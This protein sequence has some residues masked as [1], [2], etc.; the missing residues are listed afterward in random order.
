MLNPILNA[1][2]RPGSATRRTIDSEHDVDRC[3]VRL[4]HA[5]ESDFSQFNNPILMEDKI[6]ARV[7]DKPPDR[8][9]RRNQRWRLRHFVR[10][11]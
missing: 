4:R 9:R 5:P 10:R 11:A 3:G 2:E 7:E 1:R 8:R 6:Q